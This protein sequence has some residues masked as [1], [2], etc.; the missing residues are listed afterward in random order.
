MLKLQKLIAHN[1]IEAFLEMHG[2]AKLV[3]IMDKILLGVSQ[4]TSDFKLLFIIMLCLKQVL[5]DDKG[6]IESNNDELT[7]SYFQDFI[8]C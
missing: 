4:N 7:I 2:T 6:N 3:T 1:T 8:V 5:N